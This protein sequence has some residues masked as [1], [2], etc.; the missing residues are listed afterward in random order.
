MWWESLWGG[1]LWDLWC[2]PSQSNIIKMQMNRT[3]LGLSGIERE[4]FSNPY[5]RHN[6]QTR[7]QPF[8]IWTL[9]WSSCA[10]HTFGAERG[11]RES[12]VLESSQS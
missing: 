5:H 2:D 8:L 10:V 12:R 9:F 3:G 1:G 4:A 11:N 6:G 7:A